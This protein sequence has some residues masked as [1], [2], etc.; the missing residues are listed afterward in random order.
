MK[1]ILQDV[2]L[3]ISNFNFFFKIKTDK[4][5]TITGTMEELIKIIEGND[6]GRGNIFMM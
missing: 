6:R 1:R 4:L 5:K 3:S 2:L